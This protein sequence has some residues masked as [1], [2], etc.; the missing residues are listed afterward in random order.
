MA[1]AIRAPDQ[2]YMPERSDIVS[3]SGRIFSYKNRNF[4]SEENKNIFT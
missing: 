2:A 3:A 1:T 4:V